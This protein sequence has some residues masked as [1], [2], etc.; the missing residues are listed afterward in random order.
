MR[1]ENDIRDVNE[2]VRPCHQSTNYD[3]YFYLIFFFSY[4]SF[5]YWLNKQ[6]INDLRL[7][8]SLYQPDHQIRHLCFGFDSFETVFYFF[9]LVFI[10]WNH[11][12]ASLINPFTKSKTKTLSLFTTTSRSF[13]WIS[14]KSHSRIFVFTFW[15]F[16]VLSSCRALL[17][18]SSHAKI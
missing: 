7:C 1:K 2:T 10:E 5:F 8:A 12:W 15:I 4:F 3:W 16:V 17:H 18:I 11:Q 14:Y 6:K 13:S 9:F